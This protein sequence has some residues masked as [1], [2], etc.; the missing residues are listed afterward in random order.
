MA[1]TKHC[2]RSQDSGAVLGGI[3]ALS[4]HRSPVINAWPRLGGMGG[5]QVGHLE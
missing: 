3:L 4:W 5:G 2:F 1:D